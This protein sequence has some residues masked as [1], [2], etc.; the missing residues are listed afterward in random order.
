MLAVYYVRSFWF[1]GLAENPVDEGHA[2]AGSSVRRTGAVPYARPALCSFSTRREQLLSHCNNLPPGTREDTLLDLAV[3]PHRRLLVCQ[4]Y[5]LSASGLARYFPALAHD[6]G[7]QE[8]P[9]YDYSSTTRE[10]IL[11]RSGFVRLEK[12]PVN[13]ASLDFQNFTK[14]TFMMHPLQRIMSI[15]QRRIRKAGDSHDLHDDLGEFLET[16][17]HSNDPEYMPLFQ[18]CHPCAMRYDY[19]MKME[20]FDLDIQRM[21]EDTGLGGIPNPQ[22][23]PETLGENRIKENFKYDSVLAG[24]EENL[25]RGFSKINDFYRLDMEMHGYMWNDRHSDCHNENGACC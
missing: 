13:Q 24:L 7:L 6:P 19:I 4:Q 16:A 12:V 3:H 15:H 17:T 23:M 10:A 8:L 9:S 22:D 5:P 11:A 18:R 2:V 21:N 25:S 20:T 1:L 14:L